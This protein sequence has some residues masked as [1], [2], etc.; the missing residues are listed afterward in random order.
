MC[1]LSCSLMDKHGR[2]TELFQWTLN[3]CSLHK[4]GGKSHVPLASLL[5][6]CIYVSIATH[7]SHHCHNLI[8][9]IQWHLESLEELCD[10]TC[11]IPESKIDSLIP[12]V[13]WNDGTWTVC[14]RFPAYVSGQCWFFSDRTWLTSG[15]AV[16]CLWL[17]S[18]KQ[19]CLAQLPSLHAACGP[20]N[21]SIWD[22]TKSLWLA[23]YGSN[24]MEICHSGKRARQ[25]WSLEIHLWTVKE[26]RSL[27][28]ISLFSNSSLYHITEIVQA[29]W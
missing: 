10:Q 7:D 11:P 3:F 4:C 24:Q 20:Y 2:F 1:S 8:H 17:T 14:F 28:L 25:I 5:N 18:G 21:F 13:A 15:P 9:L 19:E 23:W 6:Q 12:F 26:V 22:I 27:L 29:Y 16:A